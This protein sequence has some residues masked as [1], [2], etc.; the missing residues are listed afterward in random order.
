MFNKAKVRIVDQQREE[1]KDVPISDYEKNQ[2]LSK[3]G[4]AEE[5]ESKDI[6][7]G[8]KE[9][10]E[11]FEEMC[12]RQEIELKNKQIENRRKLYGSKP[13]TFNSKDYYSY[14]K[15]AENDGLGFK[16]SVVSDMK[17]KKN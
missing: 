17:I 7:K 13:K 14:E 12:R 8:K 15:F 6:Q 11:T 1:I 2:L 16:I 3:Y 9:K 5:I 10:S 4:Y